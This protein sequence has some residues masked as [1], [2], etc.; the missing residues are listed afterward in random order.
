MLMRS[1][2][3]REFDRFAPEALGTRMRPSVVPMDAYRENDNFVVH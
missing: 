1:D 2:P 3:V